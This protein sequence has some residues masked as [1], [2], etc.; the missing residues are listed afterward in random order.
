MSKLVLYE[1]DDDFPIHLE[2]NSLD[3]M[4]EKLVQL[5]REGFCDCYLVT[6]EEYEKRIRGLE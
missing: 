1:E 6:R 2:A 3:E 4:K 5:F